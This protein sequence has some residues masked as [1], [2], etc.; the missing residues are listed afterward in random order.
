[1]KSVDPARATEVFKNER[2]VLS[3]GFVVETARLFAGT[4][5]VDGRKERPFLKMDS[6]SSASGLRSCV[7]FAPSTTADRISDRLR[8]GLYA[9]LGQLN[10]KFLRSF[11]G[12]EIH[13][14]PTINK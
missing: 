6:P 9:N 7:D 1:M 2:R 5:G 4:V 13:K 10:L 8:T 3:R 12:K 11:A 14:H